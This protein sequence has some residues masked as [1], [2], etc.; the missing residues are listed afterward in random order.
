MATTASYSRVVL[1]G[2]DHHL[3]LH[4]NV[5]HHHAPRQPHGR[6]RHVAV[7]GDFV[8]RVHDDDAHAVHGQRRADVAHRRRFAAARRAEHVSPP[9]E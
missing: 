9:L 5:G 8:G 7:A 3:G 2:L 1:Y 4:G 6:V